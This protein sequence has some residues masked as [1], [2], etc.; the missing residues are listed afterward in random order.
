MPQNMECKLSRQFFLRIRLKWDIEIMQ[1]KRRI[2]MR[3]PRKAPFLHHVGMCPVVFV[4]HFIKL[5]GST[6]SSSP[7]IASIESI[8]SITSQAKFSAISSTS[9]SVTSKG[10]MV[11]TQRTCL[12]SSSLFSYSFLLGAGLGADTTRYMSAGWLRKALS[13]P[14]C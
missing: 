9:S 11:S 14:N 3:L 7:S 4:A 13:R 6:S 12:P 10:L 8:A 1:R 2:M 5:G